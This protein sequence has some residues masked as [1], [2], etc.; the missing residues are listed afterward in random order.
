MGL[1]RDIGL[2]GLTFVSVGAVFGSGWLFAPLLTSQAAGPAALL[3]WLIGA[4]AMMLLAMAFAEVTA[5]FPVAGGI[6]R[7]PQ[8]SHGRLLAL[9]MGWSAWA[10]Y[11][12][13][14]PIEVE[15]ALR[16]ASVYAP[17]IHSG[18]QGGLSL[19]G[20]ITAAALMLMFTVINAVGVQWFARINTSMTWFKIAVPV[21]FAVM[22]I[23]TS[24][25]ARNFTAHGG[26]MPN[27]VSGV[28]AAIATGGVAFA[29]VGFRH[30]I[31]MAGETRD[32]QRTIPRALVLSL[33]IS[34]LIYAGLQ[35]AFM[36][37]LSPADLSGGWSALHLGVGQGPLGALA[38]ALGLLWLVSLLNVA[39]VVS[40]L[41]GGLIATGSNGRLAMAMANNGI[42]PAVFA[43]LNAFG[44]P[45]YALILNYIVALVLLFTMPFR[46][47]VALNG[48]AIIL[49]FLAG[50]IAVAALRHLASDVHRPFRVPISHV[51][52]P[53]AFVIAS[54]L[55]FWTGWETI[56]RLLLLLAL[57]LLLFLVRLTIIGR[58]DLD[59]KG[60]RWFVPYL[61]AL[62][63]ISYLG[64]FGGGLAVIPVHLDS[65]L[66]ALIS[67]AIFYLAVND[68][69]TK[70]QFDG[71]IREEMQIEEEEYRPSSVGKTPLHGP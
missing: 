61:M 54:L 15:A 2:V 69:L 24:F 29:F 26:F 30:A 11:C 62:T 6:A 16:Y 38:T 66:M 52:A 45:L 50:P 40:P 4:F 9:V 39:A 5:M 46:E 68:R 71:F 33:V 8:F 7:I 55:I 65:G 58:E 48:A 1:K 44:V 63:T 60:V 20:H 31:D 41:G 70:E 19:A 47:I 13:T 17:W 67:F 36:G 27:G 34:L 14:A 12:T 37:A 28:F 32:P 23:S 64:T 51:L 53:V 57:G 49:S 25:D 22:I 10:G 56:Y 59:P 3:A 42:F 43:R 18:A 35:L 21:V